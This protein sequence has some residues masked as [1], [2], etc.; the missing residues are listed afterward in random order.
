MDDTEAPRSASAQDDTEAPRSASLDDTEASR[1][2]SAL[3]DTEVPRSA[4]LDD[5]EAPRSASAQDFVVKRRLKLVYV[6]GSEDAGGCWVDVEGEGGRV[7]F[8]GC[9]LVEDEEILSGGSFFAEDDGQIPPLEKPLEEPYE[10]DSFLLLSEREEEELI[11]SRTWSGGGGPEAAPSREE[12]VINFNTFSGGAPEA[13]PSREEI[14]MINN[15]DDET[16]IPQLLV[17]SDHHGLKNE[18]SNGLEAIFERPS[19]T[20]ALLKQPLE[21]RNNSCDDKLFSSNSFSTTTT[22]ETLIFPEH[23]DASLA[24]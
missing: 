15:D 14:L 5:T 7:W 11:A 17:F 20:S 3:D 2:A 22:N 16:I 24:Q 9:E 23:D 4:S 13:A 6:V 21:N 8:P 18:F 1:S 10:D 12:I 19:K